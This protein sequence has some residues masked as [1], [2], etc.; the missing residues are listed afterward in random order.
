VVWRLSVWPR[1]RERVLVGNRAVIPSCHP[2]FAEPR[3]TNPEGLS[4]ILGSFGSFLF[5]FAS[6]HFCAPSLLGSFMEHHCT[7]IACAH[8]PNV[9]ICP[10]A[11]R[12]GTPKLELTACRSPLRWHLPCLTRRCRQ[13]DREGRV[14]VIYYLMLV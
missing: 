9:V 4:A 1:H 10:M 6:S 7:A 11:T 3:E 13:N 12:L 5:L 14:A 8:F 2:A